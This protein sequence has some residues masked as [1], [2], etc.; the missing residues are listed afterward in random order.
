MSRATPASLRRSFLALLPA[1]DR[2]A[3]AGDLA[4][5]AV[6]LGLLRETLAL[7]P[8]RF[9][10]DCYVALAECCAR[11]KAF[12]ARAGAVVLGVSRAAG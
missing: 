1:L 3:A 7:V 12:V 8:P 4:R 11:N 5:G 2:D 10:D 9:R 6:T